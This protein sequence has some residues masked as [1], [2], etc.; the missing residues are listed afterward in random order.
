MSRTSEVW[1]LTIVDAGGSD[2]PFDNR[3]RRWLKSGL[4][5]FNVRVCSAS[6]TTLPEQV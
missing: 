6:A 3:L 4:R 5:G 2:V 1:C